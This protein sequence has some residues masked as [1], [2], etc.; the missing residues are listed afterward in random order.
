MS[1]RI[2]YLAAAERAFKAAEDEPLE[3]QMV[4][5]LFAIGYALMDIAEQGREAQRDGG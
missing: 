1:K 2:D 4:W 3:V 5:G